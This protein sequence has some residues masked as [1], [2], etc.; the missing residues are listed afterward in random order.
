MENTQI[1]ILAGGKGVRMKS[2]EPKALVML[3][4]KPLIKH[5]LD[6]I[7]SLHLSIRPIIVIG[8]MKERMREVLGNDHLYAVQDKPL[9]TGH[10]VASAKDS[11]HPNHKTVLVLSSDQPLISK[12][13]IERL[14][15]KHNEKKPTITIATVLVPDFEEWRSALRHFGRIIR[16]NDGSV[17]GIIEFKDA[18]E[19]EK[20]IK[21]LNPAVYAFDSDWLWKNINLIKNENMQGEYYLTDL[22]KMA[23]NQNKKIEA[24]P[25]AN[26]IEG[27]QPNTREELEILEKLNT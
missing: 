4:N 18:T 23:R 1:I 19:K 22:I 13:T 26:L 24:V 10:A 2:D 20:L 16:G 8:H 7:S 27:L 21:E 17:E 5:I 15:K 3:K 6:T 9:G 11:V 25:V 14:L 12:E